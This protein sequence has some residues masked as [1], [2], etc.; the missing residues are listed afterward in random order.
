MEGFMWKLIDVSEIPAVHYRVTYK[1][2]DVERDHYR[3][4]GYEMPYQDCETLQ[5][6]VQ[7]TADPDA[8]ELIDLDSGAVMPVDGLRCTN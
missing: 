7:A 6:A 1:I 8:Y 4:W 3:F 5:E 2:T